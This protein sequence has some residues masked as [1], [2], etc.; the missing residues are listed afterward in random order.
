MTP[1]EY[2]SNLYLAHHGIKG[3]KHGRRRW[4][5]EDGS[6]TPAGREHYGVGDSRDEGSNDDYS[7][8][9]NDYDRAQAEE[10]ESQRKRQEKVDKIVRVGVAA[11]AIA[12]TA[13]G[14][15]KLSASGKAKDISEEKVSEGAEK[16]KD[17]IEKIKE[18]SLKDFANIDTSKISYDKRNYDHDGPIGKIASMDT[19]KISYNHRL[20]KNNP[21]EVASKLSQYAHYNNKTGSTP[22]IASP[23]G[24]SDFAKMDVS[25]L[26]SRPGNFNFSRDKTEAKKAAAFLENLNK[27]KS[28][29][30]GGSISSFAKMDLSKLKSQPGNFNFSRNATVTNNVAKIASKAASGKSTVE[31][32]SA[33]LEGLNKDLLKRK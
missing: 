18:K 9:Y 28:S 23:K 3:Q 21:R 6:L 7:N 1:E 22:A 17:V 10:K 30:T 13:Y 31:N 2:Y 26:K 14:L 12:V 27:G 5:N 11:A 16:A 19:S 32:V 25:K 33:L 29:S 20:A 15:K 8:E 24:I 4:Q